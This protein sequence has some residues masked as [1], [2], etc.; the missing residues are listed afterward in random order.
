MS[1]KRA[2]MLTE[3]INGI[4]ILKYYGWEEYALNNIKEVRAIESEKIF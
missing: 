1:D 3:Y 4:R 2:K